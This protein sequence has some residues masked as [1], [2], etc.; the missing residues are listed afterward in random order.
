MDGAKLAVF[1][2]IAEHTSARDQLAKTTLPG[3]EP[4]QPK[5]AKVD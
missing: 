1:K 2:A 3:M 4:I 5:E